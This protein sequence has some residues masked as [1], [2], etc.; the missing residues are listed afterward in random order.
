VRLGNLQPS[1]E[2]RIEFDM[3]GKLSSELPNKWTLRIPS[4]ISPRYQ[5]QIDLI[6]SMFKNLLL[7]EP[8]TSETFTFANTEWD[9]KINLFSTKKILNAGSSSHL[10]DESIFTEYFRSYSLKEEKLPEKDL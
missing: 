5:T 2:V 9:F 7:K 3:I 8:N 10:L 6:T 4:H 1:E